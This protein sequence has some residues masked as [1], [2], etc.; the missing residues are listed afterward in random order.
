MREIESQEIL[1]SVNGET[2]EVEIEPQ[3]TLLEIL[4][5]K[6]YLTGAKEACGEG[7]CGSCTVLIDG[8]AV[9][10]CIYLA[11][12]AQG[13]KIETVEGLGKPGDLHPVQSA[14]IEHGA[15]QCGFCTS[16]MIMA[17]KGLLDEK[18]RPSRQEI[19]TAIGGHLCRCTGYVKIVDAIEAA[20]KKM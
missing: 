18:P 4:R 20:S 2:L 17:G 3:M 9:L 13:K 12:E 8:K 10:S 14:F 16:G 15:I 19:R 11:V 1:L 6:L 5:E 7:D